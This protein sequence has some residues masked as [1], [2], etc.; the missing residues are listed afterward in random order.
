MF[1]DR[2]YRKKQD[3]IKYKKLDKYCRQCTLLLTDKPQRTYWPRMGENLR[4]HF[5][6]I[7]VNSWLKS[8]E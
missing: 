3:S 4:E 2:I 6:F 8:Y 7:R 1:F 5:L